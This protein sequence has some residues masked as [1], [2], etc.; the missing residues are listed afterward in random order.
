MK[1]MMI[2]CALLTFSSAF[3]QTYRVS[4]N[5]RGQSCLRGGLD[6]YVQFTEVEEKEY[7]IVGHQKY[8]IGSVEEI[9]KKDGN[10]TYYG[11]RKILFSNNVLTILETFGFFSAHMDSREIFD[12][13]YVDT[14]VHVRRSNGEIKQCV[15]T[16]L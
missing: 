6:I 2:I 15:Y 10:K 12:F 11:K 5:P 1:I 7:F 8:E 14:L 16:I 9:S 13:S 3:A 4:T